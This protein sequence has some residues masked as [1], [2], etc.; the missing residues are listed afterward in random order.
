MAFTFP[1]FRLVVEAWPMSPDGSVTRWLGPLQVG[2][3]AAAQ[4]L[5]QRYFRR[6]VGLARKKLQDAPRRAADEEDVAL[7]AF[8]SFCRG[9]EEGRFPQLLDRDGLWHL[10]VVITA[11]KAANLKR[12][13]SR[14][15]RGGG[16]AP[17]SAPADGDG[18][19]LL[20]QI[21]SREPTPELA[22]EV[23]E[24]CRRLLALLPDDTLRQVAVWRMEDGTVEEIADRL[25]CA[26][27]SVKRK[28]QLIRDLWE[29][30]TVP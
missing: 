5:W 8:H 23:A 30:E 17:V 28:L 21:L 10:L 16:G 9:A 26:P 19:P 15:K 7:S 22:A 29:K 13:E 18:E 1:A 4:Q 6:L 12:D 14:L 27:R 3:P 11:R 2:D 25:G 20:E 24:A